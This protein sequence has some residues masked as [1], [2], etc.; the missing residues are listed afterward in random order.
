MYGGNQQN[1][2]TVTELLLHACLA[3]DSMFYSLTIISVSL[4]SSFL[5]Q[6]IYNW[7]WPYGSPLFIAL[8]LK[9]KK[10]FLIFL[11]KNILIPV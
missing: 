2:V 10:K 11:F 5:P 9:L 4:S 1:E 3:L 7:F 8:F 6:Y